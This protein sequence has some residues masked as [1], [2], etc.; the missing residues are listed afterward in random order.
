MSTSNAAR[1]P[2]SDGW[3]AAVHGSEDDFEPLGAGV[4]IDSGRVLT[5]AHVVVAEGALREPLWVAFPNASSSVRC[6]V[7]SVQAVFARPVKDLAVLVL[8]EPVPAGVEAAPLRCPQ[9]KDLVSRPWWAYGFPD[10]DPVGDSAD[11]EVGASLSY[12]WARLDTRSRYPDPARFQWRRLVVS[13]LRC[14]GWAGG[15]GAREWGWPSGHLVSGGCGSAGAEAGRAG[16]LVSGGGRRGCAG[17]V[18]LV[19]GPGSGGGAAL[20]APGPWGEHRQ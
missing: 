20:A 10:R 6:R 3:V 4:V 9:G 19:A 15:A 11:G 5:C 2:A 7:D 8:E 1:P 17:P 14:G 13:R 18:G 12:G 16:A